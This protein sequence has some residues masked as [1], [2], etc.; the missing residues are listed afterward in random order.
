MRQSLRFRR[1]EGPTQ[2][3]L[4][5]GVCGSVVA[6][7]F[8]ALAGAGLRVPPRIE[9]S[10]RPAVLMSAED[11]FLASAPAYPSWAPEPLYPRAERDPVQE[12]AA[13]WDAAMTDAPRREPMV[14]R[15]PADLPPP[16]E[17]RLEGEAR[18]VDD[19]RAGPPPA[20]PVAYASARPDR[21]DTPRPVRQDEKPGY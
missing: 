21:H 16:Y 17:V 18:P 2:S 20:Q 9:E 11:V 15:P 1:M 4:I 14:F 8:G 3:L 10:D 12:F 19:R 6:A 5:V 7:A 13:A